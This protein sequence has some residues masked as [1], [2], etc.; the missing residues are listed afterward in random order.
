MRR[1]RWML[2]AILVPALMLGWSAVAFATTDATPSPGA[3]EEGQPTVFVRQDPALGPILTDAKGMTLYL[4]TKDTTKGESTCYDKCAENWPPFM[5]NEPFSLP[6][7]VKGELST[8]QRTDGTSQVAF[9]GIPLYYF[10][11]DTEPGQTNGQG[12]GDV[13]FVVPP[14]AQF[15]QAPQPMATPESAMMAGTP[16]AAGQVDVTL[17]D[18]DI[19]ASATTFTVG[20]T[21]T[22]NVMNMGTLKHEFYIE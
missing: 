19:E 4:F 5:A 7:T 13:W 9:N 16:A 3:S 15:G 1:V 21:Y 22:F 12:V 18:G 11:K 8:V 20:Q 14:D 2:A 10:A 17:L 6:F